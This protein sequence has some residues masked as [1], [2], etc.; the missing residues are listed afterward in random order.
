MINFIIRLGPI[1]RLI[2][3]D[4][5]AIYPSNVLHTG[6]AEWMGNGHAFF[7]PIQP[8]PNKP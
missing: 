6:T 8:A 3:Q 2:I 1:Q 5:A 7:G 4:N